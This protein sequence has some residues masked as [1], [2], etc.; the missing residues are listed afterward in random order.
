MKKIS[1]CNGGPLLVGRSGV[2][3]PSYLA[4]ERERSGSKSQVSGAE[5]ERAFKKSSGV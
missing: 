3:T 1:G 5:R 4:A 2:L